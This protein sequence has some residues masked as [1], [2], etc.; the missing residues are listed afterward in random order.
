MKKI[1]T[2][3]Q[4]LDVDFLKTCQHPSEDIPFTVK[5]LRY[6][7]DFFEKKMNN[8]YQALFLPAESYKHKPPKSECDNLST[9]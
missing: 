1:P 6:F 3:I 7:H 2:K 5:L 8:F 9:K 4:N